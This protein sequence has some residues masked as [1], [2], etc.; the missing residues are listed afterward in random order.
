MSPWDLCCAA[1]VMYIPLAVC[2][3]TLT[4]ALNMGLIS[5][6]STHDQPKYSTRQKVIKIAI[7]DRDMYRKPYL[8]TR[9]IFTALEEGWMR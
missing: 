1:C 3:L 6:A 8:Q 4:H 9:P 2:F 7:H 5:H